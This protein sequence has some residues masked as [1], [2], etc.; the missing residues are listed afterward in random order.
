MAIIGLDATAISIYGKGISRYQSCLLKGLSRLDKSNSYYIFL[1]KKNVLPRLPRQDNFRYI[2]INIFNRI[3]WD[4]CQL[5]ALIKKYKL[6]LYHTASDTLPLRANTKFM[7]YLFEIPDYRLRLLSM[8]S[9]LY[10]RISCA[11]NAFVFRASLKKPALI[12]ASSNSTK[13]DLM[14]LYGVEEDKLRVIYSAAAEEFLPLEDQARLSRIRKEYN[15]VDGY[16]FH[17]SSGDPRDNTSVVVRA[18]HKARKEFINQKKLLIYGDV[19][20]EKYGLNKL[21]EA[22]SLEKEVL[23]VRRTAIEEPKKLAE[24]YQAADIYVDPSLYEGFGLQVLEAM[25]CGTPVITSNITSLPEI[26]NNAGILVSPNDIEGLAHNI[27][28][29]LKDHGLRQSMRE[30]SIERARFFSWDKLVKETLDL[31]NE[32]FA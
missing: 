27:V 26:V 14:Q 9:S 10:S 28:R 19:D 12:V 3:F 5:P 16:L 13:S 15:T 32:L 18:F 21:I 6:D 29:V 11:Y 1:D 17:I 2:E 20:C 4:Q 23:F 31:Y 30:K 8:K 22:L 7:V 24:L 25:S